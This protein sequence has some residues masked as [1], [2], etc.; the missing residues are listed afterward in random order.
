MG[1]GVTGV[2][3]LSVRPASTYALQGQRTEDCGRQ[4][5]DVSHNPSMAKC[6]R[7]VNLVSPRGNYSCFHF[8]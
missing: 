6:C 3:P 7:P 8:I 4:R 2:S 5:S 1:R